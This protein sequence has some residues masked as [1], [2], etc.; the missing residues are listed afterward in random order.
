MDKQSL[1][2]FP[3][4]LVRDRSDRGAWKE[5]KNN[6]SISLMHR[7]PGDLG[8][9]VVGRGADSVYPILKEMQFL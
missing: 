3:W 2:F 7:D 4:R 6:S 1:C 5:P 8:S 9:I